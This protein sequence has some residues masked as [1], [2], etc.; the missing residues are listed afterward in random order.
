[1][2]VPFSETLKTSSFLLIST[3]AD[4]VSWSMDARRRQKGRKGKIEEKI[5]K[6]KACMFGTLLDT[7]TM[8]RSSNMWYNSMV[9]QKWVG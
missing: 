3:P 9:S 1:M 4:I 6:T 5:D 2:A 8:V 7:C